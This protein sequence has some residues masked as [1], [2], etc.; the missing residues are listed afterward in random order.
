MTSKE[1]TDSAREK[2]NR[3]GIQYKDITEGD[4][5]VLVMFLNK[6]LKRHIHNVP[7][8]ALRMS[9]KIK[10]KFLAKSGMQYCYLTCNG[11][12]FTGREAI[13]FNED[14]FIGFCG[15]ADGCNAAPIVKA[16]KEWCDYLVSP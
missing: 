13:S 2:F 8:M 9:L 7:D 15:W 14:G 16:F 10:A 1:L 4:I 12:Y 5:C 11:S 3:L 6:S